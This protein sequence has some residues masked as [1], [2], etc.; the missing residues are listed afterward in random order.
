MA[1]L[2]LELAAH[3]RRAREEQLDDIDDAPIIA[4]TPHMSALL[5]EE[6][7]AERVRVS[8][9]PALNSPPSTSLALRTPRASGTLA[10]AKASSAK[11][12]TIAADGTVSIA[13]RGKPVRELKPQSFATAR[14]ILAS[15]KTAAATFAAT[16]GATF[17][18]IPDHQ[19]LN[20]AAAA[21]PALFSAAFGFAARAIFASDKEAKDKSQRHEVALSPDGTM[22]V[23]LHQHVSVEVIDVASGKRRSLALA[24]Q[25]MGFSADGKFV[26]VTTPQGVT[27]IDAATGRI[28]SRMTDVQAVAV[29][30]LAVP[31]ANQARARAASERDWVLLT[32]G[33]QFNAA[34]PD[35]TLATGSLSH[36]P[37]FAKMRSDLRAI[38]AAITLAGGDTHARQATALAEL[39]R[40]ERS[41]NL[42][43]YRTILAREAGHFGPEIAAVRF[44]VVGGTPYR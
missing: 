24:A 35:E 38:A 29:S 30:D 11:T 12:A 15:A 1:G 26:D 21:A 9:A 41:S 37:V 10:E 4:A 22:A 3:E 27:R 18:L 44:A 5:V 19:H 20:L 39:D 42:I 32:T 23:T 31:V 14:T 33:R 40:R 13:E 17:A 6:V 28:T 8:P 43:G 34:F 36:D 2:R 25:T 16:A 7:R